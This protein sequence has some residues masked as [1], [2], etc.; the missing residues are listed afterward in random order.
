MPMSSGSGSAPLD[1]VRVVSLAEQFPGGYA[2]LLLADLGADVILVER[3]GGDPLRSLPHFFESL[4]RN[5]RSVTLN[6]K[7]PEQREALSDLL[8]SAD[9]VLEGFRPGVADRLGFGFDAV[10]ELHPSIVYVSISAFGQEGPYRL[11]PAHDLSCQA[12]AGL[13]DDF[14]SHTPRG[15]LAEEIPGLA[16]ADLVAGIFGA[17]SVVLGILDVRSRGSAHRADVSM[18]DVLVSLLTPQLGAVL[19]GGSPFDPS[20]SPGY[21]VFST[22]DGELL[23]LSVAFEDDFW[24][25]LCVALSMDD[26]AQVKAEYRSRHCQRLRNRVA[27]AVRERSA[28][29]LDLLLRDA[30]VPFAFVN[31]LR[32]VAH[33]PQ[34]MARE[35][36]VESKSGHLSYIRQ[37]LNLDGFAV[38]RF[39]RAPKCGE[40]NQEVLGPLRRT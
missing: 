32:D 31:S 34:V 19:N 15:K 21:G 40:H 4:N 5:K 22:S 28:N 37:P 13:L 27:S 8:R 35:L 12:V 36:V 25:R 10:R 29:E 16:L 20:D 24:T 14:V 6:L 39:T 9:A 3:P 1:G 38:K 2:T 17:F 23:A 18:T 33:D 7:D 30:D 11:R 26:V